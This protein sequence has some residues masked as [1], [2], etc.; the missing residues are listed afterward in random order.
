MA[1][2]DIM[3]CTVRVTNSGQGMRK[4]VYNESERSK[5]GRGGD[6][7]RSGATLVGYNKRNENSEDSG[8]LDPTPFNN[9]YEIYRERV[10]ELKLSETE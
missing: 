9:T 2:S 8:T 6:A 4:V 3:T 1:F 7:P 10:T 5:M